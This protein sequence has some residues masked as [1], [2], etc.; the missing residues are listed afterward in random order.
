MGCQSF[1]IDLPAE[2]INWE[3]SGGLTMTDVAD[4][5]DGYLPVD[6]RRTLIR[7]EGERWLVWWESER[8]GR[9]RRETPGGSQSK[10]LGIL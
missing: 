6:T 3:L 7:P 9:C 2:N 1:A 10:H 8:R 5:G 4:H